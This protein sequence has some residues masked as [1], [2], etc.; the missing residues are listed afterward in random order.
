MKFRNGF[1]SNSSSSSF[2]IGVA[3]V[4]YITKCK[5][6][7]EENNIKDYNYKLTTYKELKENKPDQVDKVN[8]SEITMESFD[9][10]F[11]FINTDDLKDETFVLTYAFYGNE[12]DG[13]FYED[14]DDDDFPEPDYDINYNFFD[15]TEKRAID[16]LLHPK[17]AGLDKNNCQY[18]YGA[19]RNG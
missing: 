19:G 6:Y 7:L 18:G 9:Y 13:P 2:I 8:D 11:V 15:E 1:V 17:Q 16:M 12:G 14:S 3:K 10:S 4:D 5:K